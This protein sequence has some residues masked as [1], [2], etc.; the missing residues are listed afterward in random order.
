MSCYLQF[1]GEVV[2]AALVPPGAEGLAELRAVLAAAVTVAQLPALAQAEALALAAWQQPEARVLAAQVFDRRRWLQ[3]LPQ[4]FGTLAV[5]TPA[6]WQLWP[7]AAGTTDSERAKWGL[8]SLRE[9][10]QQL[11]AVPA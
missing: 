5:R 3:G 7:V 9:L 4:K 2:P 10:E 11:A 1:P 8:P 6:G